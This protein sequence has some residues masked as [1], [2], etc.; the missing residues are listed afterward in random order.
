M[1]FF[2]AD[3]SGCTGADLANEDQPIFVMGGLSV[4]DGGWNATQTELTRVVSGY[5]KGAV[6]S[7]FEL[8]ATELLHRDGL[9]PFAGHPLE[10]RL[11]L[12]RDVL[13][14]V[15]AQGHDVH[16]FAV[17]KARMAASSCDAPVPFDTQVPYL[18]AF[19]YL[20]TYIN[21][22]V[23][24]HLG[25]SARGM[26]ILDE[27]GQFATEIETVTRARR[28][29]GPISHR[30][31]WIVEFSYPVDSCKNPMVQVS[32]LIVLCSRRFL[33]VEGGYRDQWPT[34]VK[35]FYAECYAAIHDRI[36]RKQLV[37]RDG[38]GMATLN[39]HLKTVRAQPVG[40]WKARY[41]ID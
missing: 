2:Y 3:E 22:Q 30:V 37:E 38:R 11:Q 21:D 35:Q 27:K 7:G 17:D 1:H 26:V 14:L 13:S 33:E 8:H 29:E 28:F 25:Q 23:K 9:G 39:L 20:I 6:P 12:A 10:D 5:F 34:E 4:R 19:D 36:R 32:D 16:L 15:V 31:K 18:C 41:G 40:Q 24:N